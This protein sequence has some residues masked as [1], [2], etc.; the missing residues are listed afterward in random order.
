MGGE[1]AW[2]RSEN[3]SLS[4]HPLRETKIRITL[5]QLASPSTCCGQ[6]SAF[7]TQWHQLV[8]RKS[9]FLAGWHLRKREHENMMFCDLQVSRKTLHL[10]LCCCPERWII[11]IT[12]RKW[13]YVGSEIQKS[14]VKQL[15]STRVSIRDSLME[16]AYH[17]M[18][19]PSEKQIFFFQKSCFCW[20]GYIYNHFLYCKS[21]S[22][23]Q[24]LIEG[25]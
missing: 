12:H 7:S 9:H 20:I 14:S 10:A 19:S 22:I 21:L 3:K 17:K 2:R 23:L 5:G 8:L 18:W 4:Q 25:M 1:P 16:V 6:V 15:F 11:C 13:C 24:M